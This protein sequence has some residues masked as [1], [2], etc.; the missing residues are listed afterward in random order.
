M[1]RDLAGR[2]VA[3]IGAGHVGSHVAEMLAVRNICGE[4]IIADIDKRLLESQTLDLMDMYAY[5]PGSCRIHAGEI[6]DMKDA[7]ILVLCA[8]GKIFSSDRLDELKTSLD[9][10]D[11]IAPQIEKSGFSG[12]A[13]AV[14]NPCDLITYYLSRKISAAVFGS[15]T[16]LDSIRFRRRI[17]ERAGVGTKSVNAFCMGEHGDSQVTVWSRVLAGGNRYQEQEKYMDRINRKTVSAGWEIAD[18]KGCTEFG[19]GI[20]VSEICRCIFEDAKEIIPCSAKLN[21]EFGE[22][23]IYAGVPCLIG[24]GGAEKVWETEIDEKELAA[25]HQSCELIRKYKKLIEK[26]RR[27]S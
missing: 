7:D 27:L 18:A 4:I 25:F 24:A 23:G 9:I 6:S 17:A 3:V 8:G 2:K 15:G 10:V 20:T 11:E 13:I 1:K 22:E 19:I 26:E 14:T 5:L 16:A 12:I 21:G